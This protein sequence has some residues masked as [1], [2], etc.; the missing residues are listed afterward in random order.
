[1]AGKKKERKKGKPV[2]EDQKLAVCLALCNPVGNRALATIWH[3]C[4]PV[5]FA[6]Q[7]R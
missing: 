1:M 5:A 3:V 6:I 2:G 4:C 7:Q